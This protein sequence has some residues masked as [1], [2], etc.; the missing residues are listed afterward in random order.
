MS[1]NVIVEQGYE[2]RVVTVGTPGPQ[3]NPGP[4]GPTGPEGPVGPQGPPVDVG[5]PGISDEALILWSQAEAWS[6][7]S[8]TR[9]T[10]GIVESAVVVWPD[11]S[12]GDFN[13]LEVD[14]EWLAVDSYSVSHSLSGKVAV[15]PPVVRDSSTGQVIEQPAMQVQP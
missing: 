7:Q 13:V 2:I 6:V 8:V 10:N 15:Q 5:G 11:G 14:G 4:V 9:D 12:V 3:G 1:H